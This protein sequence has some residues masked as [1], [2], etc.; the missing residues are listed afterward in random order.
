METIFDYIQSE[1]TAYAKPV[2]LTEGWSWSMKDHL[3]RSFLYMNSQFEEDNDNRT[4][5]PFK[6]IVLPILNIQFRTEG[7][8]VKD[9]QIYVD[10][11][12]DY[13]KSLLIKKYHD[14]WAPLNEIDTFIDEVVESYG[15]YGGV[16]VR[17]TKSAKP[18]VIDLKSL[19]FCN[20]HD[21]L[22]NPFAILHKMSFA[23]L[24][25]EAKARGWGA[26]GSDI[27]IEGLIE[28]V[29][30][31]DKTEV[32]IYE[33]HGSLPE[34]WL[35]DE[36]IS[37]E[38]K[39]DVNQIQ[40]VA[41]YAKEDNK[42]QGV[43]LLRKRMP[44][45]PFKSLKRD[46]IKNRALGRGGV[47]ELF[48]DQTWT[49]WDTVKVT[50]MLDAASKTLFVSDD[51]TFK[52]RNNLTGVDNNEVLSVMEGKDI[53]QV[54]TYP[55]NLAVFNDSV[56]RFFEH[57]KLVGSASDPLIGETPS[58]GT[59]FKLYEAQQ[60]EGRGMHQYRQGKL[61]TF[62]DEIY[63]DWILPHLATEIVKEQKF[64]QELSSDE[65]Q[66][67]VELVLVKET[68]KFK[69]KMILSMQ[70][71]NDDIVDMYQEQ[72]KADIA[73]KGNKRFF[74][75]LKGEMQDIS[76]SV[77]TNIAGKQKNLALM[78]DKLVNTLRQYLEMRSRGVDTTGL[79]PI[80]NT[81]LESSGMSPITF[82]PSPAQQQIQQP[83]QVQQPNPQ[84]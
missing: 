44:K 61:A 40:I 73:K 82:A 53:R 3:N 8:D 36:E 60:I 37:G 77:M 46:D 17:K 39:M 30:K 21:I 11:A 63:R 32:D 81:I 62:M 4:F 50:E 79:D 12:D 83:Q 51:P 16:L 1:E 31:D 76:L 52:T 27:D 24:R 13:F 9:I 78:T 70:D 47:E 69:K 26:D 23:K 25:R 41:F 64:M 15:T 45:S 10:N 33:M 65:M 57:A 22:N 6:N 43:S 67:V 59:P 49:N 80:M 56:D 58:S 71:I 34:E 55:R 19:A 5:R 75:I 35:D 74:E 7:F 14:T 29:K 2:Q 72:I 18:K 20:Q 66:A 68:N 38:S 28:L 42:K 84:Q 54:D 48:E